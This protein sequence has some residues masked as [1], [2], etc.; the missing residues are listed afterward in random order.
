[1]KETE[2]EAL[3]SLLSDPDPEIFHYV[4][5][6]IISIGPAILDKLELFWEKTNDPELHYRIES[7]I[8]E[9]HLDSTCMQLQNWAHNGGQ[10]L[11]EGAFICCRYQYPGLD[12]EKVKRYLEHIKKDAWL[13]VNSSLTAMEVVRTINKILFEIHGFGPN[14][15]DYGTWKNNMLN[16]VLET[17]RGNSLLLGIIYL[18]I[19]ESL[20]LPIKGVNLPE[21]F[22]LAFLDHS[23]LARLFSSQNNPKILFYINPYNKGGIFSRREI[24]AFLIRLQLPR[25]DE[26]FYPCS[27]V[28]IIDRLLNNLLIYFQNTGQKIKY[29]ETRRLKQCLGHKK[30]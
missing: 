17:K 10:N 24:E 15:D 13:E 11:L 21:H 5:E 6:K 14:T 20:N 4:R 1:M 22:V 2:I 8:R 23:S 26:Y 27:N 3:I 19:A 29:E 28:A 30:T 12:V 9:I 16:D 18:Y 7:L 25:K